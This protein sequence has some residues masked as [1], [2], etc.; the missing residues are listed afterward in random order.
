MLVILLLK[1]AVV[2]RVGLVC[3][4]MAQGLAVS[5]VGG[6][7]L[8]VDQVCRSVPLIIQDVPWPYLMS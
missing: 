4:P 5:T 3:E 6:S 2:K 8:A 7:T 1:K